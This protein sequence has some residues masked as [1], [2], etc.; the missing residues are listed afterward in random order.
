LVCLWCGSECDNTFCSDKCKYR[1][2]NLK[3][4]RTKLLFNRICYWC[5][6]PFTVF[7]YNQISKFCCVKCKDSFFNMLK[8]YTHFY[9]SDVYKADFEAEK[10]F[11]ERERKRIG[12]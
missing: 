2:N 9:E 8:D 6:K 3:K 1:F 11:I 12:L 10:R 4:H 5:G 7:K